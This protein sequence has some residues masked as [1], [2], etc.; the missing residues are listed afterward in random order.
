MALDE[1][2]HLE[3]NSRVISKTP[4]PSQDPAM[5]WSDSEEQFPI[6]LIAIR[7]NLSRMAH[8]E[9]DARKQDAA[10]RPRPAGSRRQRRGERPTHRAGTAPVG[11]TGLQGHDG[12]RR[13][14]TP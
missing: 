13:P 4:S 14:L 3:Y 8:E 6:T 10:S 2:F 5:N 12:R 9:C 7:C 1:G 11:Q